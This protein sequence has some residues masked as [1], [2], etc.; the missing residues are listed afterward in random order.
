MC[1]RLPNQ[2]CN[3]SLDDGFSISGCATQIQRSTPA[4]GWAKKKH[5]P[6]C[7]FT[8]FGDIKLLKGLGKDDRSVDFGH[9]DATDAAGYKSPRAEDGRS[10]RRLGRVTFG[11]RSANGRSDAGHLVL[12]RRLRVRTAEKRQM[13]GAKAGTN[14]YAVLIK[15]G[16]LVTGA[17]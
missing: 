4:K 5:L 8:Y 9:V 10:T 3:L 13:R 7:T 14:Q 15:G 1:K 6:A 17:V 12:W 2:V 16:E 11:P